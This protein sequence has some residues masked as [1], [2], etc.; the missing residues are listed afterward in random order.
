MSKY[1]R[2]QY[3]VDSEALLRRVLSQL[4]KVQHQYGPLFS[5]EELS[6]RRINNIDVYFVGLVNS[7]GSLMWDYYVNYIKNRWPGRVFKT[8]FEIGCGAGNFVS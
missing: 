6:V 5:G 3:I 7:G 4:A 1:T 8:A 2:V